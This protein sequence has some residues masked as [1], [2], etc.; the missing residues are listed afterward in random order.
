M[1]IMF[2]E[3]GIALIQVLLIT[4]ILSV[5]ALYFT[6]T[7]RD[8]VKIAQWSQDKS[9]ALVELKSAQ[10]QLLFE[11]L[12]KNKNGAYSSPEHQDTF[13][14]HWN[15][16]SAPF[17][18]KP[19]VKIEIQD[20]SG[21]LHAYFPHEQR[22]K[23]LINSY[24]DNANQTEKIYD[25]LLD[26]QDLDSISRLNGEESLRDLSL[27]RNGAVPSVSDFYSIPTVND[28]LAEIFVSNLTF[29]RKGFFNP[30]NASLELLTALSN[31]NTAQ[32]LDTLRRSNQLTPRRFSELTGIIEDDR[33]LFYP[34]NFMS[35]KVTS[36]V[37]ESMVEKVIVV[38]L[39]PYASKYQQPINILSNQ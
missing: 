33:T 37:G 2:K 19:N 31:S 6:S 5:L 7:A 17:Y 18:I 13:S 25:S 22:L 35:I 29:F 32:Q 12:T 23:A 24:S 28:E 34:S 16:F 4:A 9:K 27:I 10:S 1:S 36:R 30:L 8:Q 3:R 39:S 26:W 38:E 20:Q 11:L 15:F 14:T 21:L